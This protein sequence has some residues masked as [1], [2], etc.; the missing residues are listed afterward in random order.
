MIEEYDAGY[1]KVHRSFLSWE[2]HDVPALVSVFMHC[3]LLA[4]WETKQWHGLEIKRG[5]FLTSTVKLSDAC[6]LSRQTVSECLKRL[7]ETGELTVET[8]NK[9]SLITVKNYDRYQDEKLFVVK[10]AVNSVVKSAV[11]SAVKNLDSKVNSK[12]NSKVDTTK[13]VKN[14]KN[15]KKKE[16]IYT[17]VSYLND[18]ASTSYKPD[19]DK[20]QR[21]ITARLNEGYTVDDFKTV[22]DKKTD[23]WKDTEMQKYLRPETLF[24][25]KFE[26]YL[27]Q[28]T[29][30][31]LPPWYTAEPV[32]SESTP[33]TPE[34]IERVRRL[35][36][37]GKA[38]ET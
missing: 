25:T 34:E 35:I 36:W 33:A 13:E 19:S 38:T 31:V 24:G 7:S 14:L 5:Q 17:V 15:V 29:H 30:N 20:T 28:Q 4:N 9:Y 6:G 23:E 11:K 22:I 8:T 3:L 32:R 16:D 27:N 21:L 12:V 2:W 1:I 37:K 26:S 10:P 18:R